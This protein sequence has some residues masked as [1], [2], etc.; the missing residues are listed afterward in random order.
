[1]LDFAD[2]GEIGL[3]VD[4]KGVKQ[5]ESEIGKGGVLKGSDLAQVF[6]SLRANDLI[7]PYVVKGYLQGQ[8]PPPFDRRGGV[9]VPPPPPLEPSATTDA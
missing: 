8:A 5:K 7:W 2:T 4:E 3:L 1:M 6:A 9:S